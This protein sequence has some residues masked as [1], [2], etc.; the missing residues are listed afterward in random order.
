[1]LLTSVDLEWGMGIETQDFLL[2]QALYPLNSLL[3]LDVLISLH[4]F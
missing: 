3:N 1:M 2:V 4:C